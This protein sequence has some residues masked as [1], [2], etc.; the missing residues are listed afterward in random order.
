MAIREYV[1][2]NLIYTNGN[3]FIA[4]RYRIDTDAENEQKPHFLY[5][6]ANLAIAEVP[7]TSTGNVIPALRICDTDL[8]HQSHI[9]DDEEVRF[10]LP[11]AVLGIERHQHN[12]GKAYAWNDMVVL[13]RKGVLF[14]LVNIGVQSLLKLSEPRAGYPICSR[15]GQSIS[16]LSSPRAIQTFEENHQSRCGRKVS[17]SGLYTDVVADAL[18]LKQVENQTIAYSGL[19]A[20]RMGAAMLLDMH[21]EDLQILVIGDVTRTDVDAM[22]W[23]PMAGGSGLLDTIID[24]FKE[25]HTAA[26]R[27]VEDCPSACDSSCIDCMQTYRNSFYHAHLNRHEAAKAL[28]EWGA[29]LEESHAIPRQLPAS[30]L[31]N[32]P[33]PAN[34]AEEKLRKLLSYAGFP[35]GVRGRQIRLD[36]AIGT[37]T[38]DIIYQ[39]PDDGPDEGIAIYLDGMSAH[40]H[41]NPETAER[42]RMIRD[43]LDNH[44]WA[45][46]SI[47]V[48]EL[49]DRKAMSQ[50]FKKLARLLADES[51]RN[52]IQQDDSWYDGG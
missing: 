47:T 31:E 10:Q 18:T 27:I 50:K 17:W 4:R 34:D 41:G 6:P 14:R 29:A 25:I 11:T 15:C 46:I 9:S 43:W 21:V 24:R 30:N 48:T 2:G 32:N 42:D 28:R 40:I 23:D 1:P 26:L 19:E 22:L 33:L 39:H 16:P 38:P 45:V 36:L 8:I 20:L 5:S 7:M 52:R 44:G 3:R 35:E 37:T 49:D 12:G 51:I 13:H